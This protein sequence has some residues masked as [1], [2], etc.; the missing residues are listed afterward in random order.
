MT[1]SQRIS[2]L[3]LLRVATLYALAILLGAAV[4]IA[5]LFMPTIAGIGILF[6]RG[7]TSLF[8]TGTIL[9]ASFMLAARYCP[10]SW[11]LRP[12]DMVGAVF[13][14]VSILFAGF[15]VGP[16]T[17]DRSMSMFM[18]SQIEASDT[19]VSSEQLQHAFRDIYVG[20]WDQIGRR[21]EEQ[22]ISGNVEPTPRGWR[23]TAQGRD[24]MTTARLTSK[25]FGGD[26]RF[27]GRTK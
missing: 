11:R 16:V 9:L 18:L 12:T 10:A 22:R 1:N 19:G 6:Y 3:D 5:L 4:F 8:A 7:V 21:L 17:V 23:L 13:S 15:I 25:L 24:V 20:Q 2:L 26:P 27:V 14:A